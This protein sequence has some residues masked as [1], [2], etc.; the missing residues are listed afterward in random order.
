MSFTFSAANLIANTANPC[1]SSE[2]Q[3]SLRN[4]TWV[5]GLAICLMLGLVYF[6][7]NFA[8]FFTFPVTSNL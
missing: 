1:K 8:K 2:T 3:A 6:P 5:D 7:E 4:Q